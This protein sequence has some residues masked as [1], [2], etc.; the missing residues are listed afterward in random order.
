MS[1]TPLVDNTEGSKVHGPFI[2]REVLM[3]R[4]RKHD[5][6]EHTYRGRSL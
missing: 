1:S 6:H 2:M 3:G 4:A 5:G